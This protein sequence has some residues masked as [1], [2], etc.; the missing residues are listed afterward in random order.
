[1]QRECGRDRLLQLASCCSWLQ[2]HLVGLVRVG[3]VGEQEGSQMLVA[4]LDG[5]EESRGA[6]L[7]DSW[8][9]TSAPRAR[10]IYL[11]GGV[12]VRAGLDEQTSSSDA[13]VRGD[14]VQRRSEELRAEAH[15][16]PSAVEA[17]SGICRHA[18]CRGRSTVLAH[19]AHA[20]RERRGRAPSA[21]AAH[22]SPRRCKRT[23]SCWFTSAFASMRMRE[24]SAP[25]RSES[26]A[27]AKCSRVQPTCRRNVRGALTT[28]ARERPARRAARAPDRSL[29]QAPDGR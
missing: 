5:G 25:P 17:R 29:W 4:T 9:T 24:R 27:A 3:A 12:D 28:H 19:D 1:M 15:R 20:S 10:E 7:R 18:A 23:V 6:A 26:F 8:V 22:R 16:V 11:H 14:Q 21:A 13:A 2:T